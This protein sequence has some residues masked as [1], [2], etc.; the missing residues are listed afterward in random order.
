MAGIDTEHQPL[1]VG[2]GVG[3]HESAITGAQVDRRRGMGRG[4]IG[5]LADVHL[6]EAASSQETHG[7]MIPA[8]AHGLTAARSGQ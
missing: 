5:Q 7:P 4:D 2:R 1:G 6:G 3:Q 8:R